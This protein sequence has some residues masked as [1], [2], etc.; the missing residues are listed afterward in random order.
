[1]VLSLLLLGLGL[2]E[3]GHKSLLGWIVTGVLL[4]LGLAVRFYRVRSRRR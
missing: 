1:M 3:H 4:L 2:R